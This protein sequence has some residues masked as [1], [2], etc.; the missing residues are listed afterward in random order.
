MKIQIAR[1][2][3]HQNAKVAA[4]LMAVS[5]MIFLIPFYLMTAAFAPKSV[6]PGF[7]L[8]LFPV[9]YLVMGYISAAIGCW[10]YNIMVRFTGGLEFESRAE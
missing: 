3:I 9:I 10:V 7:M 1:F 2:S 6:F 8:L 4:V 5:A